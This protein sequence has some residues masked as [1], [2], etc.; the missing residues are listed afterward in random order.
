MI[1]VNFVSSD[2]Y[3]AFSY[4][5]QMFKSCLRLNATG[6][7]RRMVSSADFGCSGMS[8]HIV[9]VLIHS[10]MWPI[11]RL[12]IVAGG[13]SPVWPQRTQPI[14]QPCHKHGQF[15]CYLFIMNNNILTYLGELHLPVWE[16]H[17]SLNDMIFFNLTED[18]T[19][20]IEIW[21]QNNVK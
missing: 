5:T 2:F 3:A 8:G 15:L 20:F 21:L 18:S 16:G 9:T 14:I 19:K 7:T 12:Q 4:R 17:N 1:I 6:N 13:E 10:L 11:R